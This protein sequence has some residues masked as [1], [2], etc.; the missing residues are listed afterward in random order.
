MPVKTR[1]QAL[2]RARAGGFKP[3][4]VVKGSAGYFIAP[5]GVTNPKA[6]KV[7]A[8]LRSHGASKA[9]AAKIAWN[10]QKKG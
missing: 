4:S 3:S 2:K 1:A 7:Y 9:K 5:H 6:K 10:K 8:G